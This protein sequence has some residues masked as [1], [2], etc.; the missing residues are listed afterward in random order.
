MTE[1]T[2]DNRLLRLTTP[3]GAD[4][5]LPVSLRGHEQLSCLFAFE[6]EL[7]AELGTRMPLDRLLGQAV[8]LAL[9]Q[10]GEASRYFNG[11]VVSFGAC[12]RSLSFAQYRATV[13]PKIWLLTKTC[14]SRVFQDLS[15]PD[16][17]RRVLDGF[18][19]AFKLSGKYLKRTY[20]V[21]YQE[22][23]FA[24]I[25][26]L[27]EEDGITY[28]FD[29]TAHGHTM[30][31]SDAVTAYP[32]IAEDRGVTLGT[33]AG[34]ARAEWQLAD[35][36]PTQRLC[37]GRYTLRDHSFH[38]PGDPL[39]ATL[40]CLQEAKL[41][42]TRYKLRGARVES[43][44][45]FEYPGGY[46]KRHD[47]PANHDGAAGTVLDGLFEDRDRL[48]RM[49][50]EAE[51]C[52][53]MRIEGQGNCG[54]FT[55]GTIFELGEA[56][57]ASGHYLLTRVDHQAR[58]G[59]WGSGEADVDHYENQFACQ[60]AELCF[61]PARSTPRP[62]IPGV[63]TATVVGP[64]GTPMFCDGYGRV[65]VQFAW[66][67]EGKNDAHSS[68]W[69]RVAQIWAGDGWGAFF[70]PRIGHEVVVAFENGD[71]DCPLILGSV[72]NAANM[73]PYAMPSRQLWG[74]IRSAS[75]SG[76]AHQHF[77]SVVFN[78]EKGSEHLS[79]HSERNLSLNSECDKMIRAGRHK[80]ER[81][82]NSSIFAVGTLPG[83]G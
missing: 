34:R 47:R 70:W 59:G 9:R 82:P 38:M 3:L 13:A 16:I 55:P 28:S 53:A 32:R 2:Q 80:G 69:L 48:L 27:M 81:V 8:S 25:S 39:E 23:D 4:M 7:A 42:R 46:A 24:F 26:R 6:L 35:W 63:Q 77:N 20:C 41:G 44:E 54:A 31:L 73:P 45:V 74:G 12:G 65:K 17:L 71:P 43:P 76:S 66:D 29:H 30:V 10:G 11:I 49:R 5:L 40:D 37:S 14:R 58:N 61:R 83:A 62:S 51:E 19:V 56:G 22:T 18:D 78:D 79:I 57:D 72:Y 21:Q 67:R 68:C 15:T 75:S 52:A 33:A 36:R 50:V 64:S 60:S 1:F